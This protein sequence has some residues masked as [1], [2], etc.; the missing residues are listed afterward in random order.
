[1]YLMIDA[2]RVGQNRGERPWGPFLDNPTALPSNRKTATYIPSKPSLNNVGTDQTDPLSLGQGKKSPL[3][4]ARAPVPD[5]D[6]RN[7]ISNMA[8]NLSSLIYF[9]QLILTFLKTYR[10]VFCLNLY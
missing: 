4:E 8:K 10:S 7:Y 3:G 2:P 9:S 5:G 6:A 1:M